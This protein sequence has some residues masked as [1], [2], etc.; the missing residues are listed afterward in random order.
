MALFF[1]RGSKP[2]PSESSRDGDALHDGE[3]LG[4]E[5]A[6]QGA[7]GVVAGGAARGAMGGASAQQHTAG[8]AR[9]RTAED[10]SQPQRSTALVESLFAEVLSGSIL[11][12]SE[13]RRYYPYVL[14]ITALMFLYI[15]NGYHIQRLHRQSDRLEEQVKELRVRSLTISSLRMV[16]TRQSE[17]MR[18][19][20]E[21]GI[22]LEESVVPPKVV[23]R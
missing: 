7:T 2:N 15:A 21:R 18:A 13:V 4:V 23:E 12:R 17:V 22:A 9:G 14:F 8:G 20:S 5:G 3:H 11:T 16:A 19:L 10:S 6:Q 1:K